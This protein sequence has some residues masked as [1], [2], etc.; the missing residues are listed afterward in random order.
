M[1]LPLDSTPTPE[2]GN[3][4]LLFLKRITITEKLLNMYGVTFLLGICLT[5][6]FLT[7]KFGPAPG[8]L[9]LA[10]FIGI[11]IVTAV[12]AYPRFGIVVLLV[13]AFFLFVLMRLGVPFPAG[14]L[15]DAL[16]ALLLL[17]FFIN[18]KSN[19]DWKMFKDPLSIVILIWIGYNV[20]QVANPAS[21]SRMAWLYTIR[22]MAVVM[23][24]YFVFMYQIKTISFLKFI[25][26]LWLGLALF[27]ALY[28]FKQEHIGFF[29]FESA[30][31]NDPEIIGLLFINGHWRVFSIFSDPVAFAYNM[32]ISI[33]LCIG[34]M[35]GP[36]SAT[37]KKILGAMVI[38]FFM[39]M[40]YSGTRGAYVLVPVA[41]VLLAILNFN[42]RIMIF[43]AVAGFMLAFIIS[44]PTSNQ[45]LYRFQ[46]A[47]K[48]SDDASFNVRKNNQKRI[49]PYIQSHPMGGGLGATGVWGQRFAPHSFLASFPPDSG[50]V[51]VAVELGWLGLIIFCTFMFLVL[52]T[53]VE[54]FYK[55]KD[56][57]LKSIALSMLLIAFALNI[58]NYPQ[59]AFV[60][61]P[62][63]I[64]F[65]MVVAIINVAPKLDKQQSAE[66]I[67]KNEPQFI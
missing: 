12:V 52:K 66:E 19:P 16:Q 44:I 65:Y 13:M 30:N 6:G 46:S 8:I 47:F 54:N 25:I 53:G 17:G 40:L 45:T 21:E 50:Y 39:N 57:F 10:P 9:I 14:T 24:M 3:K 28:A 58:G 35:F 22:S 5:L 29:G 27:S 11:P 23:T 18:Q 62:T 20:L 48:P 41:L 1:Q 34:L 38:F 26:K 33:L 67:T 31:F 51:R 59:E 4:V 15:M 2:K 64:Y 36:I 60:Q 63:S 32:A 56:P 37:K 55:I 61:F 7:G 42:R 43:S 49:Q